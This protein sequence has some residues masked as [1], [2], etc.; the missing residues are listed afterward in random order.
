MA[1]SLKNLLRIRESEGRT[2]V[3]L[4]MILMLNTLALEAGDVVAVAGFLGSVDVSNILI[5]WIIDMIMILAVGSIQGLIVDRYSRMKL[6]RAFSLLFAVIFGALTLLFAAGV[7]D[8]ITYGLLFLL[9]EQQNIFL[10]LI[11][12]IFAS[13][14]FTAAQSRRLFPV[15]AS[16]SAIGQIVGLTLASAAPVIRDALGV[17]SLALLPFNMLLYLV[18]AALIH[19]GFR[20]VTIQTVH[21]AE[22]SVHW[23]ENVT[24]GWDYIRRIEALRYMTIASFCAVI[25][26]TIIDYH[27]LAVATQTFTVETTSISFQTFYGIYRLVMT[28]LIILTQ[29]LVAN[30]LIE[31]YGIKNA[32]VAVPI[33]V[34]GG[35]LFVFIGPSLFFV[36]VARAVIRLVNSSIDLPAQKAFLALMP[37]DVRGAVSIFTDGYNFA[38]GAIIASVVI[39]AVVFGIPSLAGTS[40]PTPLYLAVGLLFAIVGIIAVRAMYRTYD[41]TLFNW[42]LKRR[43]RT[44][45]VLKDLEF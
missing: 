3:L 39:G 20:K 27:F 17:S 7:S 29:N 45:S 21:T 44:A 4:G 33:I 16:W 19:Y 14:L 30:R 37:A 8:T 42:R 9:V 25:V 22:K 34:L 2:V 31:R 36:A 10:P 40:S 24:R 11:F 13:E 1:D 6:L 15:I 28:I 5:L 23:R 18:S 32:L 26:L 38:I 12:W 35:A 41:A 43:Q